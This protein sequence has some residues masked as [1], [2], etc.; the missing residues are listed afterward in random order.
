MSMEL[1]IIYIAFFFWFLFDMAKPEECFAMPATPTDKTL[2]VNGICTDVEGNDKE[3]KS[4]GD[5]DK[6]S[7]DKKAINRNTTDKGTGNRNAADKETGGDEPLPDSLLTEDNIYEYTFSDFDKAVRIIR[8]M[9][10]RKLLAVH[11]LDIAEGDLYFNTGRYNQALVYYQRALDCDSVRNNDEDYMDQL[12][13]MVSSY[14]CLHDEAKKAQYVELLLQKAK[15]CGNTAMQSVALFNMGKMLYY[16]EDKERGYRLVQEGIELMKHS[17]YKY[18]YDNL[19]YDYNTLLIMQQRDHKYKEALATLD[20]LAEVV[21]EA[22]QSEPSIGELDEKELKTLYAQRALV[23]SKLG[24]IQEAEKAYDQWREIGKKYSKDD[25]LI[26]PYLME[27]KR[28]DEVIRLHGARERFLREQRDTV[29]YH[30]MTILRSLGQ[31][32]AGKGDYRKSKE[33]FENL[34]VLTDSLK[35]REQKSA[36]IELATVYETNEKEAQLRQQDADLKVRNLLLTSAGGAILLLIVFLWRNMYYIRTIR[37]K[38]AAMIGSIEELLTYKDELLEKRKEI[39]LLKEENATW[40]RMQKDA[41]SPERIQEPNIQDREQEKNSATTDTDAITEGAAGVVSTDSDADTVVNADAIVNTVNAVTDVTVDVTSGA[42]GIDTDMGADN[43][44]VSVNADI[45]DQKGQIGTGKGVLAEADAEEEIYCE[46]DAG[47]ESIKE[48][49]VEKGCG[50]DYTLPNEQPEVIE[51]AN[52]SECPGTGERPGT[53]G[54]IEEEQPEECGQPERSE[55]AGKEEGQGE[56]PT[57]DGENRVLF[58]RLEEAVVSGQLF[59]HSVCREELMKLIGV[60]KNRFGQIIQQCAHT[61]VT[62][63]INHK[64][65]E[66]AT[67]LLKKYPNYTVSVVAESCGIPNIPTFNRLFKEKY[68]MTP[69]DFKNGLRTP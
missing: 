52:D 18:K 65:L 13:R 24:R 68:G 2:P 46:A 51:Q 33:Y 20:R 23:L 3:I 15:A 42:T 27:R 6:S 61:N 12:H 63:Y 7:A 30:M 69:S 38:N 37:H 26:T 59:L 16:Q 54:Q 45:E 19:R 64:R 34:A 60:D 25:Y 43:S 1:R 21:T 47:K 58:E 40:K 11:R 49:V 48:G 35:M 41:A 29:N 5:T 57:A 31:A 22:T 53:D 14:D 44:F 50:K 4:K 56:E 36:A 55:C 8:E 32:Y 17:D 39:R 10:K 9:R 66:Y 67:R 62:T 28:Y